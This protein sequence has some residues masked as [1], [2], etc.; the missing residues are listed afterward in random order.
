MKGETEQHPIKELGGKMECPFCK[1]TVN[2]LQIHLSRNFDCG[3]KI[4]MDHFANISDNYKKNL[5]KIKNNEAVNRYQ[6][7]LKSADKETFRLRNNEAVQR[8]KKKKKEA[9]PESFNLK[10]QDAVT[11]T[12]KKQKRQIQI[13]SI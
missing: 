4:D 11:R 1:I 7:K 9:D 6:N 8:T 10:N 2:N 13:L 12:Q 3:E 5:K